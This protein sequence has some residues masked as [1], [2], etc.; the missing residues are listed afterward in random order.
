MRS[1]SR[2][3]MARLGSSSKSSLGPFAERSFGGL[4]FSSTLCVELG[5]NNLSRLSVLKVTMKS[6]CLNKVRIICLL[7]RDCVKK[8]GY[9]K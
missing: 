7:V 6:V 8:L 3:E 9:E 1:A 4:P 2:D 5:F